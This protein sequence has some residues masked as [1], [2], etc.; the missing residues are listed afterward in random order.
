MSEEKLTLGQYFRAEREKKGIDLKE[1]EEITKISAQTLRFLEDDQIDMLPPRAFLRGF[2]QVISKEFDLDE[3][4]LVRYLDETIAAYGK[5]EEPDHRFK[6]G[7]TNFISRM[8]IIIAVVLAL[9]VFMSIAVKR[10]TVPDPDQGCAAMYA[11]TVPEEPRNSWI[12]K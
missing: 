1:I 12:V 6:H 11:E 7:D 4:E 10:C 2:L 5:P 3:E 8:I 9:I